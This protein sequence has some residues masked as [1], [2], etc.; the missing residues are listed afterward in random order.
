MLS[1][2]L[3][4]VINAD[5]PL[6]GQPLDTLASSEALFPL[7]IEGIDTT[8]SQTVRARPEW[9][10]EDLRWNYRYSDLVHRDE[11]GVYVIDY[12]LFH[13]MQPLPDTALQDN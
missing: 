12:A 10:H 8:T 3:M 6:H 4:H 11:V 5:S 2:T 13:E 9:T 1:W 7:T